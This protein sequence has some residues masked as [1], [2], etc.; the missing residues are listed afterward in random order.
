M[1]WHGMSSSRRSWEAAAGRGGTETMQAQATPK[2]RH[3]SLWSLLALAPCAD[4]AI[5]LHIMLV[6]ASH[7]K[8]VVCY[9]DATGRVASSRVQ[10]QCHMRAAWL[11]GHA[12]HQVRDYLHLH[13]AQQPWQSVVY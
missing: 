5:T 6:G 10:C 9:S 2:R 3:A 8:H 4:A 7:G 13:Q 1:A 11:R 12:R